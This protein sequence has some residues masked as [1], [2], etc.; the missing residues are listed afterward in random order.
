M[1]HGGGAPCWGCGDVALPLGALTGRYGSALDGQ[2]SQYTTWALKFS[3][4]IFHKF[5]DFRFID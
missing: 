3:D 5:L 2:W 4:S 1:T